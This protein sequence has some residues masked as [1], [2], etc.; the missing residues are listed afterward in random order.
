MRFKADSLRVIMKDKYGEFVTAGDWSFLVMPIIV[1]VPKQLINTYTPSEKKYD[2]IG[3]DNYIDAHAGS[4]VKFNCLDK[5][6]M[7]CNIRIWFDSAKDSNGNVNPFAE[8]YL[9]YPTFTMQFK[10]HPE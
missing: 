3:V 2:I 1:D 8:M 5:D 4:W 10:V 7:K 6:G 9:D